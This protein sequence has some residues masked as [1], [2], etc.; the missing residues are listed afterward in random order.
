MIT[1]MM[2]RAI[3]CRRLFEM[4]SSGHEVGQ[5]PVRSLNTLHSARGLNVEKEGG[6]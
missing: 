5:L 4:G 1:G 6:G 2:V 3:V